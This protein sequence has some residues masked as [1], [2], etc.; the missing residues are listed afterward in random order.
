[1]ISLSGFSTVF[2][3]NLTTY[4]QNQDSLDRATEDMVKREGEATYK[5][6]KLG[7]DLAVKAAETTRSLLVKNTEA[8]AAADQAVKTAKQHESY[9]DDLKLGG[10]MNLVLAAFEAEAVQSAP[11]PTA[12]A[13][14]PAAASDPGTSAPD[15][16]AREAA[17]AP[18]SAGSGMPEPEPVQAAEPEAA[19]ANAAG[20]ET[21]TS[22]GSATAAP[23]PAD[24]DGRYEILAGAGAAAILGATP[25][26]QGRAAEDARSAGGQS[27]ELPSAVEL[28]EEAA[29]RWAIEVQAQEQ[30]LSVVS[31]IAAAMG[32]LASAD[33]PV[34]G[35]G[36]GAVR[37]GAPQLAREVLER[38]A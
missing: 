30:A 36:D 27:F 31:A 24:N 9:V 35:Y 25:F 16:P 34:R 18:S 22:A 7:A 5:S 17:G 21:P 19:P 10:W 4:L 15:A 28:D 13:A 37:P 3:T 1:M 29:R 38:R 32:T 6:A 8:W 20:D 33:A 26:P 23:S 2:R 12:T 11:P 14:S